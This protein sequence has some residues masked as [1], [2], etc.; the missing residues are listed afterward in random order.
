MTAPAKPLPPHGTP[1]RYRGVPRHGIKGCRCNEC[2]TADARY[3]K[4]LRYRR[5]KVDAKPAR[6]RI[7]ALLAT[8]ASIEGIARAANCAPNTIRW[9]HDGTWL[10]IRVGIRD[11]ILAA[12]PLPDPNLPVPAIGSVRRVRALIAMR[13]PIASICEAVGVGH[14]AITRLINGT[15]YIKRS[16]AD[17]VAAAY[18]RL[19]MTVGTSELSGQRAARNDWAPP[20]AWDDDIDDPAAVPTGCGWKPSRRSSEDIVA[21][22]E[23]IRRTCGISWG[24]VAEHMGV[25]KNN[26][27]KARERVAARAKREQ[28]AA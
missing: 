5:R 6:L 27:D 21:E 25:P 4:H 7:E 8:G 22:A 9:T 15:D 1:A 28:L 11:R 10:Q 26:L 18:D 17:A 23:E 12:N 16:T 13:H 20:L 3:R 14:A 24:L 19:C 2:R